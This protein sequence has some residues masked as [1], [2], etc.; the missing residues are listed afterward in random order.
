MILSTVSGG[1]IVRRKTGGRVK[2]EVEGVKRDEDGVKASL[3]RC[4]ECSVLMM[5]RCRC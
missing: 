5:K 3:G 4:G 1:T 2:H